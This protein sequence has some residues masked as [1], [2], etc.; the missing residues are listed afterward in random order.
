VDFFQYFQLFIQIGL[1]K[2]HSIYQNH[3]LDGTEQ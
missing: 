3:N 1:N 2:K